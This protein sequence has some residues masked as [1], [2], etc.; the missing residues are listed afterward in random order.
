MSRGPNNGEEGAEQAFHR[1]NRLYLKN[2][3]TQRMDV[4]TT[5]C[6]CSVHFIAR[7]DYSYE[8]LL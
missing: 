3:A 6:R 4:S 1:I 8:F 5:G 2:S 7:L